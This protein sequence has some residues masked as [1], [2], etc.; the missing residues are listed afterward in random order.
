MGTLFSKLHFFGLS[1]FVICSSVIVSGASAQDPAFKFCASEFFSSERDQWA[2]KDYE[3][4]L[5]KSGAFVQSGNRY[6]LAVAFEGEPKARDSNEVQF[7]IFQSPA[8]NQE[9]TLAYTEKIDAASFG[10]FSSAGIYFRVSVEDLAGNG[11]QQ[12]LVESNSIGVC[13]SCLSFVRVYDIQ[14]DKVVKV[15]D[16]TY[17]EIKFG[18][19]EG[20]LI[21]SFKINSKGQ[22]VPYE[23]SFFT[24]TSPGK[25]PNK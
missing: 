1:L 21:R 14:N 24:R 2:K 6:V 12:I 18:R 19:G 16:E 5:L 11:N 3:F 4:H 15:V 25:S 13:S 22:P 23:K 7:L 9:L 17:S 8:G 20:L 10:E